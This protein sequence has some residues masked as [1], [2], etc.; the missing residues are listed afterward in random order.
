MYQNTVIEIPAPTVWS[1]I[2]NLPWWFFLS[3]I[4]LTVCAAFL[5]WWFDYVKYWMDEKDPSEQVDELREALIAAKTQCEGH[6]AWPKDKVNAALE[7][8]LPE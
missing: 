3:C 4:T 8:A 2:V 5:Y 1:V 6:P 7:S